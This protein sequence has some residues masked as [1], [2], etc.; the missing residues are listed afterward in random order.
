MRLA[1]EYLKI[2]ENVPEEKVAD[3]RFIKEVVG[4]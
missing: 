1:K 3:W 4:P 2:K